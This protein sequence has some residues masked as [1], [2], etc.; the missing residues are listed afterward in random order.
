LAL[1]SRSHP[2]LQ[3]PRSGALSGVDLFFFGAG[4]GA[5][6]VVSPVS[7]VSSVPVA[8]VDAGFV[9]GSFGAIFS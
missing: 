6:S 2:P 9:D 3:P 4:V 7:L 1:K 5:V 8:G